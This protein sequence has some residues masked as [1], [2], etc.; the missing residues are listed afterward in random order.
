ME[1]KYFFGPFCVESNFVIRVLL[2]VV[3]VFLSE[4]KL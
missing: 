2:C 4:E 1:R 3:V